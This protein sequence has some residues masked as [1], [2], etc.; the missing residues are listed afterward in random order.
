MKDPSILYFNKRSF[1]PL[2]IN[3][4]GDGS[5]FFTMRSNKLK[6]SFPFKVWIAK[7][8]MALSSLKIRENLIHNWLWYSFD[9]IMLH[10]IPICPNKL[11]YE[12]WDKCLIVII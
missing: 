11:K 9:V 5:Q 2:P 8:S 6:I 3:E 7:N 4:Y 10:V 12:N 1:W